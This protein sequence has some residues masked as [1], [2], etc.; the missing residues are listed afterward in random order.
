M[1]LPPSLLS[2]VLFSLTNFEEVVFLP[3]VKTPLRESQNQSPPPPLLLVTF[4]S[5]S[6][7]G[8][9]RSIVKFML[10]EGIAF[11]T[12][13]EAM[14][15]MNNLPT[16]L[17]LST[18]FRAHP[19]GKWGLCTIVHPAW[20]H[21]A[22]EPPTTGVGS[23]LTRSNPNLLW[24]IVQTGEKP[25]FIANVYL[26]NSTS[27]S[28]KEAALLTISDL[29]ADISG[30]PEEAAAVVLGDFNADPFANKGSNHKIFRSLLASPR[31]CLIIRPEAS[32]VT[33]PSSNSHLDNILC[34]DQARQWISSDLRYFDFRDIKGTRAV[35]SDHIPIGLSLRCS[36]ARS[37][38]RSDV[39][40]VNTLALREGKSQ[41]YSDTLRSLSFDFVNW[42]LSLR[43]NMR[44]L[45]IPTGN[46]IIEI[47]HQGLLLILQSA[48]H[49]TL[50]TRRVP[51]SPKPYRYFPPQALSNDTPSNVWKLINDK[52]LSPRNAPEPPLQELDLDLRVRAA[53]TPSSTQRSTR[54]WV[55]DSTAKIEEVKATPIPIDNSLLLMINTFLPL[56]MVLIQKLHRDVRGGPDQVTADQ[57]KCAPPEFFFALALFTAW[58]CEACI[59]PYLLRL[60]FAHFIS[61]K[62]G[63]RGLRLESLIAKVI[64]QLVLHPIFPSVGPSSPLICPEHLAGRRGMSAEIA[65]ASLSMM[66]G[67]IAI[68]G[69]PINA[70]FADVRGAYDNLW[71]EAAWAKLLDSHPNSLNVKRVAALYKHFICK[72]PE[73]NSSLIESRTGIPQGG[74]RSGD[75]FCF[76]TSDLPDELRSLDAGILILALYITCLVY[77]DDW[78]I[79]AKSDTVTLAVLRALFDY[80][81]RWSQSWALDKFNILCF[82]RPNHPNIWPFGSDTFS[83]KSHEK[84]LSVTFSVDFSWKLH[85]QSK[86]KTAYFTTHRMWESGLL[87]GRNIPAIS[88]DIVQRVVWASL[89]Y[90]RAS[91]NSEAPGH[92]TIRD[93]LALLQA[94]TLR[95]VLDSTKSCP[96]DALFGETGDIP[97]FW[98]ERRKILNMCHLLLS[99][100]PDSIPGRLALS[101]LEAK[102]GLMHRGSLLLSELGLPSDTFLRQNAKTLI[103]QAVLSAVTVEWRLKIQQQHRLA[104]TYPPDTQYGLRGYL[105]QDFQGRRV[106]SRLR[107]DDLALGSAGFNRY[108]PPALCKLCNRE[109]ETRQHFVLSCQALAYVRAR[110]PLAIP[111]PTL[112]LD[113][114]FQQVILARPSGASESLS[115]ATL[116]G[117]LLFDLWRTRLSL[118]N[119]IHLMLY[120]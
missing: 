117:A 59:F 49:Q 32:C 103:K 66:L 115:T 105:R 97:D 88:L 91:T 8:R 25:L 58:C 51:T 46:G 118:L 104:L 87:G 83:S 23:H 13:Q 60:G 48:A 40:Q 27:K 67:T 81:A 37:R 39:T 114:R 35:P 102:I 64:E 62:S 76:F 5:R 56:I 73:L 24:V 112:R 71:R 52:M 12:V 100:P 4:N 43:R 99:T 36:T 93:R 77:M 1:A 44:L 90:G 38:P 101:T 89:D 26:P 120:P 31:L 11:L 53:K 42:A 15:N 17:F 94:K 14:L 70:I 107:M 72:I 65:T 61:K 28:N 41:A 21:R 79:F 80:G 85:F 95:Q 74:P 57:L 45:G 92:K 3:E 22:N 82:N 113:D 84:W 7:Y 47:L 63:W 33:R 20:S 69:D 106:L 18:F 10:D 108:G 109:P 86:I 50:G 30:L 19:D 2:P 116:M 16:K 54:I 34:T 98:R 68:D 96:R 110:H 29:L 111:S 9:E 119:Q 6:V 78:V 75:I 55:S